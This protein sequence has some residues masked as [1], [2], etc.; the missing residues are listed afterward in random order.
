MQHD[1]PKLAAIALLCVALAA[2]AHARAEGGALEVRVVRP[3]PA[4]VDAPVTAPIVVLFD[5]AVERSTIDA[6]SFWAFGRWSGPVEGNYVFAAGDRAVILRP[7]APLSA[8]ERVMVVLSHSIRA[9]D[10]SPLRAA[11]YSYQY[12]TAAAPNS[13]PFQLDGVLQVRTTPNQNVRSYGG[14]A[15]DFN[16]DGWLDLTIINEDSADLRTFL[17][18]ADGS[19]MFQPFLRPPAP[20][21]R[22][23]SPNEPSDFD[24]DGNADLAV[25]N[26]SSNSVSIVLGRGDGTFAPQQEI[27]VGGTPHG[28]TVLDVDGDGDVDVVNSN[29]AGLGNLSIL[30]N[31]GN[32]VF[33]PPIFYETGGTAEFALAAADMNE[34]G[35]LDL[36]T[37]MQ[38]G[39]DPVVIVS[40]GNGDGTFS[41]L[42][43]NE[44]GGAVWMVSVGDVD[45]DGHEDVGAVNNNQST[46]ALLLG[47]GAGALA[48]PILR[49]TDTFP[50]ATDFGDIDGDADLD[51]ITSSYAGDWRLYTN[52]GS[53]AFSFLRSF[54]SPQAASCAVIMD[55]DNDGDMDLALVDEL[56]DVVLLQRH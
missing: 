23:A 26:E 9:A 50:L 2:A 6:R 29:S 45:G 3:T 44:A 1:R 25:A 32:G 12:W 38:S 40:R 41:Q 17:N 28:L 36:V 4:R 8:G 19:G 20:V 37:G 34:D 43:T 39:G 53:G 47:D 27:P 54:A 52:D 30:L 48:E 5:R 13:G 49:A 51:W 35:I 42:S 16:N 24:R 7:S 33:A 18:R 46:A 15:T 11:G 31:D 22:T 14:V 56:A 10:G 55:R 21:G